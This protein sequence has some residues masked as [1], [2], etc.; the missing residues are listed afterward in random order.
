[1]SCRPSIRE[2][3]QKLKVAFLELKA[4][5]EMCDCLVGEHDDHESEIRTSQTV[6]RDA[7][8]RCDIV[9]GASHVDATES[10]EPQ[11]TL[12]SA[13]RTQTDIPRLV[14]KL[15]IKQMAGVVHPGTPR[16]G[17]RDLSRS[18]RVSSRHAASTDG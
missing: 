16:A 3:V 14:L 13:V 6:R 5:R 8:G 11:G 17:S 7:L 12:V 10:S 1:M 15:E 2:L 9:P 4:S 18:G